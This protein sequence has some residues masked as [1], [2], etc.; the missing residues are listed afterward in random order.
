MKRMIKNSPFLTMY[1]IGY[2]ATAAIMFYKGAHQIS[3]SASIS[4][5]P[6]ILI[7]SA[8]WPALY[9][10]FLAELAMGIPVHLLK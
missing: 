1:L 2:S 10:V 6:F 3:V 5:L 8:F 4:E 9:L 7:V